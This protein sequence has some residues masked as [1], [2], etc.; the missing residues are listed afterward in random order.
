MA[1]SSYQSKN[2]E[3]IIQDPNS[4]V[5]EVVTNLYLFYVGHLSK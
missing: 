3:C 1:V 4:S 2:G 5:I